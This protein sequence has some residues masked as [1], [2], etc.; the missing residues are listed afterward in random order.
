MGRGASAINHNGLIQG[1]K[2][3]YR[4]TRN[5]FLVLYPLTVYSSAH[6]HTTYCSIFLV[7]IDQDL[8][9][10]RSILPTFPTQFLLFIVDNR[11][12]DFRNILSLL[13][14]VHPSAD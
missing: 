8:P 12:I 3:K 14:I 9:S 5:L 6:I 11:K 10:F 13:F 7:Q 1:L 2:Y 4:Y